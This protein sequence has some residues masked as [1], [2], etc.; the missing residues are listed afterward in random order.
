MPKNIFSNRFFI[1]LPVILLV[2]VACTQLILANFGTLGPWSGG[3]FG[4]FS[5]TDVGSNRHLHI[6]AV[7]P[8]IRR[9]LVL[10]TRHKKT[11]DKLLVFPSDYAIGSFG[12]KLKDIFYIPDSGPIKLEIHVWKKSFNPDTLEPNS[13]IINSREIPFRE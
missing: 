12:E 11:V 5:T 13:I 1:Y 9:E 4:M 3:G 7:T 2:F 6:F 8:N 10:K